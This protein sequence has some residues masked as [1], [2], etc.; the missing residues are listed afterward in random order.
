MN[1][2]LAN[3]SIV[4]SISKVNYN[5]RIDG[6]D[7]KIEGIQTN[8]AAAKFF[9]EMLNSNNNRLDKIICMTTT[10]ASEEFYIDASGKVI[11]IDKDL[12][13]SPLKINPSD[14]YTTISF[15][16]KRIKS[17]CKEKGI[18][19]PRFS[20][21]EIKEEIIPSDLI[22]EIEN[23]KNPNIYL[24]TTGGRRSDINRLQ[25][26]VKFL[27][28]RSVKIK[29]AVYSNFTSVNSDKNYIETADIYELLNV[30]EGISQFTDSGQSR[31][32]TKAFKNDKVLDSLLKKMNEFTES[33]QLC[34]THRLGTIFNE[35][36]E[37]LSKAESNIK[38][39]NNRLVIFKQFI[40][41]IKDKF[42]GTDSYLGI[43]EW[44]M[45][46]NLIQ[47]M[48]TIYVEYIPDFLF[49]NRIILYNNIG[50]VSDNRSNKVIFYDDMLNLR[51]EVNRKLSDLKSIFD[52]Y[53]NGLRNLQNEDLFYNAICRQNNYGKTIIDNIKN[54]INI[55][56]DSFDIDS[57]N[58]NTDKNVFVKFKNFAGK[59]YG[60]GTAYKIIKNIF[61][62]FTFM[63][64]L[65]GIP[66][67]ENSDNSS[68]NKKLIT[69]NN[70]EYWKN[71]GKITLKYGISIT[72]A[73]N[74]LYDYVFV[75]A[76]R[77]QINHAS[78][79]ENITNSNAELYKSMD[80]KSISFGLSI[81]NIKTDVSRALERLHTAL[82]N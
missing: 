25:L 4:K 44:C 11:Y 37:E 56:N 80:Y 79:N 49:N 41:L 20:Y 60:R 76:I 55:K 33:L 35:I 2:M 39:I 45:K 9:I 74:I 26:I 68:I 43:I 3:L 42:T 50:A 47:Q 19:N 18:R 15:F 1:I 21:I 59:I 29:M 12:K 10:E 75:R 32:L 72:D 34:Q 66:I 38:D 67:R 81:E 64:E 52:K 71:M 82:E 22:N 16:E 8:E 73:Q 70:I 51:D 5:C 48:L 7:S 36:T 53:S 57:F 24:D 28:Y 6:I 62:D 40:P 69:I 23:N 77:N 27:E 65:A 78:E 63:K 14:K 61:C 58:N 54:Y 30:L 31:I 13:E 46:N 17:Y